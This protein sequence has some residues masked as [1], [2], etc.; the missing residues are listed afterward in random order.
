MVGVWSRD[1]VLLAL[2]VAGCGFDASGLGHGGD[3]IG[4][5]AEASGSEE[6][7]TSA[8]DAA[9]S[10]GGPTSA[11]TT[12]GD[13]TSTGVDPSG[14]DD[15]SAADTANPGGALVEIEEAP[16]FGFGDVALGAT[17]SHAFVLR[18]VG[19]AT[20]T[21][22]AASIAE[23]PFALDGEWPGAG[24]TCTTALDPGQECT[25]AIAFAPTLPGVLQRELVIAYGDGAGPAEG[26]CAMRGGGAGAS[27][28]LVVNGDAETSSDP[29]TGWTEIA[30]S[31]WYTAGGESGMAPH[32]GVR[33]FWPATANEAEL[34]QDVPVDKFA[35]A[36]ENGGLRFEFE[37]WMRSYTQGQDD[38]RTIL[39]YRA[40]GD[41]VLATFDTDWG[42][43]VEWESYTDDRE[44]PADT[45]EIRVRLL[46]HLVSGVYCDGAYDDIVLRAVY[47]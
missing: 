19:G 44:A 45:V 21:D 25:V 9:S 11:S 30:G 15:T 7:G 31:Q 39:E 18:N 27:D 47:P 34:V 29:P 5:D 4:E 12:Q 10:D 1:I 43:D 6:Q 28:N 32:G 46:C 33:S 23:G 36:I 8:G 42:S 22:L 16:T 35:E 41:R 20:A 37:V 38:R 14:A 13:G 3:E 2:A 24:G 40:G 17:S 26:V